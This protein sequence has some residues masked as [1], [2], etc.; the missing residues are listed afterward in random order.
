MPYIV[1]RRRKDI[2]E[3]GIKLVGTSGELNFWITTNCLD[4]LD[5][6]G[7]VTYGAI[8]EVIGVLECVKLEMY[9]RLA[10]PYEDEKIK[11]NGD[12]Y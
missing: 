2:Y 12:V 5:Q 11:E 4:Y 10:A 6:G 8:N 7:S 9:R 1:D 3:K